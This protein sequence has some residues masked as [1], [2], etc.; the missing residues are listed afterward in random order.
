MPD[1]SAS[2]IL[3]SYPEHLRKPLKDLMRL[4]RLYNSLYH[5]TVNLLEGPDASVTATRVAN[6]YRMELYFEMMKAQRVAQELFKD[7]EFHQNFSSRFE[8][9]PQVH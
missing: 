6:H 7:E 1:L 3:F 2:D 9:P 4:E 5:H 8:L